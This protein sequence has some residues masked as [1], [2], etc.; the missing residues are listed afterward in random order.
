MKVKFPIVIG[1]ACVL[2]SALLSAAE[3]EEVVT[4]SDPLEAAKGIL[5]GSPQQI[6]DV[7]KEVIQNSASYRTPVVD[8]FDNIAEPLLDIEEVFNVG[9][10]PE[11]KTPV[12]LIARGMSTSVN[13]ID[14]YGKPWPIR[15]SIN[16]LKKTVLVVRVAEPQVNAQ[17][18]KEKEGEAAGNGIDISDPQAGSLNITALKHGATGNITVY[19]VN[20]STPI[21]IQ[22]EGKSGVY[23]KEATVKISEVG[24]QTD[25][26]S[27]NRGD[28]VIVGTRTDADLNN[29]LYGIGPLGSQ[30][31]VVEGGEGKA[32]LKENSIFLQT[33]LSVYSPKVA[34]VT[35]ANGR[36]RAYKLPAS[37][38]I[39]ATNN[40]GK[41]VTL[42]IKRSQQAS[43]FAESM[44][45][46]GH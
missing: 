46:S 8:T 10:D 1:V 21:S 2:F 13:F 9:S 24:P 41:S 12:V 35:H 14:A 38:T 34:G 5:Q 22:L 43:T 26:K 30:L 29:A 17:P 25:L 11:S 40:E 27:I 44:S 6:L 36:Y 18:D 23:H 37:P 33:P 3:Q 45:G 32:W 19:L 16:F 31:M 7:R 39:M 20:R 4:I 42:M 28:E 15:R